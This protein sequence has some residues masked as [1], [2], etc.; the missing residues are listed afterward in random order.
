[1]CLILVAWQAHPRYPLV[2]AAN[3]D[4]WFA[5]PA[6]AA[7]FWSDAPDLLA[8]RD[9]SAGGTWL[10]LTRRGAIWKKQR[11]KSPTT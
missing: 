4:E 2:V 8:G 5:R 11:L 10:G 1:M 9:T 7:R 6:E 3:R